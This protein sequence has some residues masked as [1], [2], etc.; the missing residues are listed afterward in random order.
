MENEIKV[1]IHNRFDIVR[2]NAKTGEILGEYVAENIILNKFWDK[3]FVNNASSSAAE[4]INYIAFGTG[5]VTPLA[6]DTGLTAELG[7]K[8]STLVSADTSQ[9]ESTG[10]CSI[11]RTIRLEDTEYIGSTISEVGF[12]TANVGVFG[13]GYNVVTKA[14]IKDANGNIITIP[15]N[16]G[17][18][19]DIFATFYIQIP[20]ELSPYIHLGN[21]STLSSLSASW[22]D[23]M[24]YYTTGRGTYQ[25]SNVC[26]DYYSAGNAVITKDATLKKLTWAVPNVVAMNGNG[27]GGFRGLELGAIR[28]DLPNPA[29]TQPILEKEVIAT[30]DGVARDFQTDFG[31]V[32]NNGTAKV[33]ANDIEQAGVTIDFDRPVPRTNMTSLFRYIPIGVGEEG[34]AFE[35]PFNEYGLETFTTKYYALYSS[36]DG[37]NWTSLGTGGTSTTTTRAIPV[38]HQHKRYLKVIRNGSMSF[39]T[40]YNFVSA[41]F[42]LTKNI[43]FVV[44]PALG[45]TITMTYQPDCIAKDD[46]HVLNNV[47]ITM[48]LN[49]YTPV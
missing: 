28:I 39:V 7:K 13:G 22:V 32:L 4:L 31:Y 11:K 34:I 43:H 33:F 26:G 37:V 41:Q 30:G 47:S 6:T 12:S 21:W 36:D 29:F 15:K 45:D 5:T 2:K 3:Y 24:A 38:D 10:V 20:H 18:I 17:E 14:L 1:N 46:K 40:P 23:E 48:V 44:A 16:A 9:W 49:E 35:N 42:A 27:L 8:L 19:I 25:F